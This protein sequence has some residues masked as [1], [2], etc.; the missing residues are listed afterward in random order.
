MK[1][2]IWLL[3]LSWVFG[4]LSFAGDG[5][6]DKARSRFRTQPVQRGNVVQTVQATGT[7][8]P[9]EVIDVG[10]QVA[11]R[12]VKLGADSR[13]PKK[14]IDF[15]TQVEAGTVL[16]QLDPALFQADLRQAKAQ[17]SVAR[18]RLKQEKAQAA[19]APGDKLDL[20]KA[21]V[22][23]AEANVA[24]AEAALERAQ[25]NL[26]YTTIRSPIAGVI[27]DRRV[28]V[29]QTVVAALNAPSLFLLARDLKQL[30]VWASVREA[31]IAQIR[32]GL[33]A[34]FTV[35]SLPKEVFAGKVLQ[36]RLN[37]TLNQ[38][39][40]T[41][42]V[43]VEVDNAGGKLLPYLTADVRFIVGERK[44]ALLVPN[45]AL[46]WRPRPDE[47]PPKYRAVL[48]N[49]TRGIVWVEDKDSIRPVEVR[50]GL[51][52][53]SMTEVVGG[54][55]REGTPVITG[56]APAEPRGEGRKVPRSGA[57]TL[58]I[59]PGPAGSGVHGLTA[60]DAEAIQQSCPAVAAAAPVVRLRKQLAHGQRSWVPLYI[61]G[62]TLAFLKVRSCGNL[63]EGQAFTDGDIRARKRV[64]LVG[65]TL[66]QELFEGQSPVGKGVRVGDVA[67]QVVGVLP[68]MGASVSGLDQDD[69]LV[70]P[71]TT[72]KD[73]SSTSA[74][75]AGQAR[76]INSLS[77]L[78]PA[79]PAATSEPERSAEV[80]L[81]LVRAASLAPVEEAKQQITALLRER[82]RIP[83]GQP[84]DFHFHVDAGAR[85][86]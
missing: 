65:Q 36:V 60:P 69:L 75:T 11:G 48:A 76:A 41:Y 21:R 72:L 45:A 55:L 29:G 31:D 77:Q 70:V 84:D 20:A 6:S 80:D 4:G 81:I 1:K 82:H 73:Q 16:A 34:T 53:E 12:V 27:I 14:T 83:R 67:F 51:S 35:S 74:P 47:M 3:L 33:Q 13:D 39:A 30:Q 50:L 86:P 17:L 52:D 62:T 22:E 18:A 71:W 54:D 42:T 7:L 8:E 24:L 43:V 58:V 25:I 61:Y 38:I 44:D 9:E 19:A 78:Y 40:V 59:Q 64:C 10:A 49:S 79:A 26:D 23:E 66:V 2:A 32:Q 56:R 37:A 5:A 15:G 28:N 57:E 46:K 85:Q 63:A 68:R